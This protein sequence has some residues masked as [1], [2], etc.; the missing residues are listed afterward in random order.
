MNKIQKLRKEIRK[1]TLELNTL[2][3]NCQHKM[4]KTGSASVECKLC[5]VWFGWYCPKSPDHTC[6]YFSEKDKNGRYIDLLSGVRCYLPKNYEPTAGYES[7]DWCI[8][9][10]SPEERK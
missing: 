1:L 6:Y 3:A 5:N 9:C 10:G 8:F 7:D 2:L 4:V